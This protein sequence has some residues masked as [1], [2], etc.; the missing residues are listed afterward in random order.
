MTDRASENERL[1]YVLHFNRRLHAGLGSKLRQRAAQR[2]SVDHGRQHSH[3]VRG[4]PVHSAQR[5]GRTAP[6]ISAANHDCDLDP[7]LTDLLDA[8]GNLAHNCGRNVFLRLRSAVLKSLAAQL[9]HNTF[10]GRRLGLH[11]RANETRGDLSW[12]AQT[13]VIPSGARDPVVRN[14]NTQITKV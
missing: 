10:V 6:D 14:W 1:S 11:R 2:E 3:V 5:C 8:F 4:G 7:E 13:L 12:K 9:E